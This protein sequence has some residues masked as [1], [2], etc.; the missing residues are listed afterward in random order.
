M[1]EIPIITAAVVPAVEMSLS[2]SHSG[3]CLSSNF[4]IFLIQER[5]RKYK[6]AKKHIEYGTKNSM[7]LCVVL[8]ML[9]VFLWQ[10]LLHRY[11]YA[12]M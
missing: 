7:E 4:M 5:Q 11:E 9:M 8:R 10:W 6:C 12:F 1:L 2:I 3:S